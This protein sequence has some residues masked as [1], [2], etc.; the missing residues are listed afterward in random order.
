MLLPSQSLPYNQCLSSLI[1]SHCHEL[2]PVLLSCLDFCNHL[3][4][5]TSFPSKTV[6][7]FLDHQLEYIILQ[8]KSLSRALSAF[9]RSFKLGSGLMMGIS[10]SRAF[11]SPLGP[12]LNIQLAFLYYCTQT[13]PCLTSPLSGSIEPSPICDVTFPAQEALVLL[14][15][16]PAQHGTVKQ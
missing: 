16:S 7:I 3:F 9:R 6:R 10:P 11:S 13:A 1:S 4:T 15:S 2:T 14:C 12:R 8:L 5:D